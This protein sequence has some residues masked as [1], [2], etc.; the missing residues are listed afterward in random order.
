M[1]LQ[2]PCKATLVIKCHSYVCEALA[3][4]PAVVV[5]LRNG[6]CNLKLCHGGIRACQACMSSPQACV[7]KH[8]QT[9]RGSR[10]VTKS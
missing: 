3:L 8:P 6:Q 9:R 10:R 4:Q 1:C 7:D 5:V 2:C